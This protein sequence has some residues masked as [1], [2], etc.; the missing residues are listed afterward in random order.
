MPWSQREPQ[1]MIVVFILMRRITL[2][3]VVE[4]LNLLTSPA[5]ASEILDNLEEMFPRF[6]FVRNDARIAITIPPCLKS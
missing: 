2:M 6:I 3:C 4:V 5:N 1:V